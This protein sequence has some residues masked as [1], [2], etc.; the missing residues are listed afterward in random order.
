MSYENHDTTS[1]Q[2]SCCSQAAHSNGHRTPAQDST[3]SA[4]QHF[5]LLVCVK[6]E[7]WAARRAQQTETGSKKAECADP[8]TLVIG[9]SFLGNVS[10]NFTETGRFRRTI[11][12][13]CRRS[14]PAYLAAAYGN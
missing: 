8:I 9:R 1:S 7:V 14:A 10:V 3:G 6:P 5:P 13:S 12:I 4:N 11:I 2:Y